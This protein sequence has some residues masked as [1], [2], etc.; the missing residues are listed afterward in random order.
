MVLVTGA[1]GI[2]GR[3]LLLELLKQGKK[4]RATKRKTSNV[5][6][7]KYSLRYYTDN[8]EEFFEKIEW[9]EVDL[10]DIDSLRF[11]FQGIEEVYHCSAKVSF[12]PK[13]DKEMM[14]T[15]V[16]GTKNILYIAE[17]NKVKKLLFISSI[18]ALD[19][20][21]EQ[22]EI[23]E[24]SEFDAREEHSGYALSKYLSEMEVWRAHA[25]GLN[26]II[27]NPGVIIGSGNWNSSSGMMF[28][29]F[30]KS[31][32][33]FEGGLAYVDVRDVAK[34]SVELMEKERFGERFILISENGKYKDFADRI[35]LGLGK[36]KTKV[37]PK[38]LLKVG[39]VLNL[40]LGW[41]IPILRMV[42]KTNIK[43]V[44]ECNHYSNEKIKKELNYQFIPIE[45]SI[46]FHLKNYI[47]DKGKQ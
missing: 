46:E 47:K 18:I 9:V 39:Y 22:G 2:L 11:A 26:T 40:L 36:S 37:I 19:K 3:V 20:I 21:N 8:A 45:E 44:T 13:D 7:V 16:E 31:S 41:L 17:E 23:D 24:S 30:E 29:N 32:L 12:D 33:T 28:S 15:N 25:E 34:I 4:V 42:N 1:T 14:K 38:F 35:R 27:V 43:A 6:E 5:D 10:E